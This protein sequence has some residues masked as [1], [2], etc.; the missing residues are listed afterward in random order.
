[1]ID[2]RA[3]LRALAIPRLDLIRLPL[4]MSEWLCAYLAPF[5]LHPQQPVPCSHPTLPCDYYSSWRYL[6]S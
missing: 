3:F 6:Q 1:M 5:F 4:D 2:V